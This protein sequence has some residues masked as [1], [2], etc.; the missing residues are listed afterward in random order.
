MAKQT[1]PDAHHDQVPVLPVADVLGHGPASLGD[2][3]HLLPARGVTQ[4]HPSTL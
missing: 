3:V 4:L 1:T 2:Q